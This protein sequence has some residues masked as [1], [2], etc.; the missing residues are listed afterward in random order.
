MKK[1]G[2][3]GPPVF[4]VN[5]NKVCTHLLESFLI[6]ILASSSDVCSSSKIGAADPIG[7]KLARKQVMYG[8]ANVCD[9][10]Y[11]NCRPV[12]GTNDRKS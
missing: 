2:N 11:K 8:A 12:V 1:S 7:D 3:R 10:K 9:K 5:S 6:I 4:K